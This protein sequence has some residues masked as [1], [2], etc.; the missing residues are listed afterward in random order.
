MALNN[1]R[2]KMGK[3]NWLFVNVNPCWHYANHSGSATTRFPNHRETA[4][5]RHEDYA[6]FLSVTFTRTGLACG[7]N[8]VCISR[9][10]S[11]RVSRNLAEEVSSQDFLEDTWK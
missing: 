10:V 11:R 6:R 3:E 2:G 1:G 8:V 5:L 4:H 9:R 7:A